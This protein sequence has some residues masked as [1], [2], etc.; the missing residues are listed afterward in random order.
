MLF[1]QVSESVLLLLHIGWVTVISDIWASGP[2]SSL[3]Y[4]VSYLVEWSPAPNSSGRPSL[5]L[6]IWHQPVWQIGIHLL[7]VMC[8]RL[9]G[10]KTSWRQ[11]FLGKHLFRKSENE[12]I[13][14]LKLLSAVRKFNSKAFI[15]SR[16]YTG[17]SH[18]RYHRALSQPGS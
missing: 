7:P 8:S 6:N 10:G 13:F 4:L 14:V 2:N 3:S 1:K 12:I 11:I 16:Q 15:T 18:A 9:Y 5:T 17:N